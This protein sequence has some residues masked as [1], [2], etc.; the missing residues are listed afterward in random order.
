MTFGSANSFSTLHK[1]GSPSFS[2]LP[3]AGEITEGAAGCKDF[4]SGLLAL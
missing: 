1:K 3:L 2:S 4:F